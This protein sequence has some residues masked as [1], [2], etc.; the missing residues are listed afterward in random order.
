MRCSRHSLII[1]HH[2]IDQNPVGDL[3]AV[4]DMMT[5]HDGCHPRSLETLALALRQTY[6]GKALVKGLE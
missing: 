2:N 4:H 5:C 3:S 6:G 1:R